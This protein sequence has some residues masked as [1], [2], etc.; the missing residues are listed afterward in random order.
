M[1]TPL[2]IEVVRRLDRNPLPYL[3]AVAMA[4]NIGSTATITGNPQN[5]IIGSFSQIG[6]GAFATAL[7]PV[8]AIGAV[9]TLLIIVLVHGDEFLTWRAPPSGGGQ[10]GAHHHAPLGHQVGSRRR[11]R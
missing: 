4:S 9:I 8:A 3:L 1:L 11:P 6:Y 7:A 5:M 10:P 2:V